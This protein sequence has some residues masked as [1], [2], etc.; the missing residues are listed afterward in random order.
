MT[1]KIKN[2]R[3][4]KSFLFESDT[5][6]VKQDNY[7]TFVEATQQGQLG[8]SNFSVKDLAETLCGEGWQH[9]N[10]V[11]ATEGMELHEA[12]GIPVTSTHLPK[13]TAQLLFSEIRA[14]HDTEANVFTPLIPTIPS[15]IKGTEIVPSITNID[16]D[17]FESV[18]EG[19]EYPTVGVTEEYFTLPGKDKKGGIIQL[20]R[21]AI[22]FDKTMMLVEQARKIGGALGVLREKESIDR[23]T[24][25]V[26][27][28]NRNG[29]ASDT[30]TTSGVI[31]KQTALPLNDWTDIDTAMRLW[32]DILDPNTNE[33]LTGMPKHLVVMPAKVAT[34]SR[35]LAA[36]GTRTQENASGGTRSEDTYGENPLS[37]L[38]L[39]LQLITSRQLYQRVL[40]T[41]EAVAATARD[42]WFLGNLDELLAWYECWPLELRQQG[43]DSPA[44]FGRDVIAQF[45]A[46][47]FGVTSVR[48]RRKMLKLENTAW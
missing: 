43:P 32:E 6:R 7:Q 47:Y 18:A 11:S 25:Y 26:N 5:G 21:E 45:K 14:Q 9:G 13:I 1:P 8:L 3:E 15:K 2:A 12:D 35:I 37:H 20:T 31:N 36:T 46:S 30:Y 29:T 23:L 4:L 38:G 19:Q 22:L 39:N 34:G 27:N 10:A 16:P 17:D 44:G 24:G 28:Y 33:P 41:A 48:E 40:A 42:G